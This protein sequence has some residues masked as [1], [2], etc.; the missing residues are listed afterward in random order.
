MNF[1]LETTYRSINYSHDLL[2]PLLE[3]NKVVVVREYESDIEP[4]DFFESLADKLGYIHPI[5]EDIVT[6]KSTGKKWIDITYDPQIKDKYRTAPV[7][8]PLHT[9]ASYVDIRDN[10]QFFYC[11]SQAS[12]GGSTVFID[13][14]FL[15]QLMKKASEQELIQRLMDTTVIF[16]KDTRKRVSPILR[17]NH[18]TYRFN[19]NYYCRDANNSPAVKALFEDFHTFLQMRVVQ[20]GLLTEVLLKKNDVVFFHDELVL[21]GRNS[22]FADFPGQRSLNKGT[23]IL[24]SRLPLNKGLIIYNK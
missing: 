23:L 6:G 13:A 16:S 14:N 4:L 20:S 24:Q 19:W 11:V 9:D 22:Y 18:N 1:L 12:L 3:A 21:H 8:Q 2:I 5:D 15:V 17:R 10:I 7:A